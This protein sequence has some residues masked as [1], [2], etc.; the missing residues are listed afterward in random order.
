MRVKEYLRRIS[1]ENDSRRR[2]QNIGKSLEP[3]LK[4]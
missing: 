4:S 1:K 2:E 3:L